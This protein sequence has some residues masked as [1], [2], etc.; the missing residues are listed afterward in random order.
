MSESLLQI[1]KGGFTAN[2]SKNGANSVNLTQKTRNNNQTESSA[3]GEDSYSREHLTK[4]N[5][6]NQEIT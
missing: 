2:L 3:G 5:L 6:P 1:K 4:G